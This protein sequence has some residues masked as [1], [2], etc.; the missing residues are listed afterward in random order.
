M[1]TKI[2]FVVTLVIVL[3]ACKKESSKGSGIVL[4]NGI[5]IHYQNSKGDDLFSSS[6]PDILNVT[7]INVFNLINGQKIQRNMQPEVWYGYGKY[8]LKLGLP[9]GN[10]DTTLL[11][12]T[13]SDI[14]TIVS[15]G[16]ASTEVHQ[17]IKVWYNGVLKYNYLVG[18]DTITIVK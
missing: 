15:I 18:G 2:I 7:N 10:M 1:K 9:D 3:Y 11:Q 16:Y 14:D 6:T 5:K 12:L 13:R 8:Y 4:G 17:T